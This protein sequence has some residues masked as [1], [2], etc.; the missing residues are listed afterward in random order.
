MS[1]YY[2]PYKGFDTSLKTWLIAYGIGAPI[3][4][5]SQETTMVAIKNYEHSHALVFLFLGGVL[6]QTLESF[7]YKHAMWHLYMGEKSTEYKKYKRYTLSVN[8]SEAYWLGAMF[9]VSTLIVYAIA[10]WLSFDALL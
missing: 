4:F 1:D 3:L 9:D 10:T 2:E 8:I 7:I 5:I 6:L